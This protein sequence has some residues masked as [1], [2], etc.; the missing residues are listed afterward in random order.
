MYTYI[1]IYICVHLSL[2]ISIS[3]SIYLYLSLSLSVYIYIYM[4]VCVYIYIYISSFAPCSS[5]CPIPLAGRE[6]AMAWGHPVKRHAALN[7]FSAPSNKVL[8]STPLCQKRIRNGY[9]IPTASACAET[10]GH[11]P[12]LKV[13]IRKIESIM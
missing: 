7:N 2:S 9:H 3:I 6:K 5:P 10:H 4:Y 11:L 1:Y 8:E 12:Y 13:I